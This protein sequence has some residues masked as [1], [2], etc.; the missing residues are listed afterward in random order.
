MIRM[1]SIL[2]LGLLF[3]LSAFGQGGPQGYFVTVTNLTK[4]QIF[5]P[6][7][8]ATH[9]STIQMFEPGD[10]ALP[11]L[12]TLAESGNPGPL[13]ALLDSLPKLVQDTNTSDGMLL[14]GESVTIKIYGSRAF[15][16]LSLAGMMVSS[17]DAFI[18]LDSM[19]LP[20]SFS[21]TMVPAYDAGSEVNDEDCDNIPGP[22]CGD[23]DDSGTDEGGT[24]YV[25][26]GI[27]G[28]AD[29]DPAEWDWRNPV[30]R[31]QIEM[32]D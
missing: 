2:M 19:V 23:M 26:N 10:A 16:R 1:I 17:N 9:K 25:S 20:R 32:A 13:Q 18:G 7:V 30:A 6:I 12:A 29:L 8:V 5:A 11:E 21:S 27:Q 14:P 15:N 31:V 4:G 28:V 24:I 3:S 22:P